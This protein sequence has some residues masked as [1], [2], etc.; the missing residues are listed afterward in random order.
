MKLICDTLTVRPE[1]EPRL[2][3][4]TSSLKTGKYQV[5]SDVH[6]THKMGTFSLLHEES[7]IE[8]L[9]NRPMGP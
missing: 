6:R 4:V 1:M 2:H 8:G 3:V 7:I 9:S 5:S